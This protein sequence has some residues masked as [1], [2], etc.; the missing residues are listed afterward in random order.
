MI[1]YKLIKSNPDKYYVTKNN[2]IGIKKSWSKK[3]HK[4]F[5][6]STKRKINDRFKES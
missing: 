3:I 6:D 2:T 4:D 1:D 5:W